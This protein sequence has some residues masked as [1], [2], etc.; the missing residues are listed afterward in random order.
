MCYGSLRLQPVSFQDDVLRVCGD[1]DSAQEGFNRLE[2]V[3]K[4]KLLN[5]HP[6]KSCY[7]LFGNNKTKKRIENE[8]AERPLI[9]DNFAVTGKT[10]EKW[11]GDILSDGGLEKSAEATI[12]NRYGRIIGAIFELKAVI[13]DLRMQMIGG[14]KCGL[15]IWEMALIPSLL[16]NASMWTNISDKSIEKLDSLQ[17]TFLQTLLGTGRACPMPALCWDTATLGMSVRIQK[18]KLALIHH[19]RGLDE[20]SLAKQIYEEQL[21]FNWPGLVR[22]SDEIIK[23]WG[24][25][26]IINSENSLT[27]NQWKMIIKKEAKIQ[28]G[29]ILSKSINE[30]YSKLECMK[31]E[32]Y[33]EKS[34][35][36]EMSMWNA[37]LHF[38]LRTRMFPCKMNYM[39]SPKYKAELWS[40]DSCETL[41]DSQSHILYCPAY[42]QLRE[43]KSLTS[44]SDIVEYFKKVLEIRTKLNLNR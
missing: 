42:K 19:I 31:N 24:V 27:K 32:V 43:G 25:P 35:L 9:Y 7:L 1:R 2:A 15:D 20:T 44:D 5:I 37:R 16:N 34:Y 40:C 22:E 39:N 4:S 11:L 29:K 12:T 41:I 28:N 14:I 30:N 21:S 10:Q 6:T 38:S 3:F 36:T 23:A 13:E 18:A 26:N 17:N 33:E 8:I